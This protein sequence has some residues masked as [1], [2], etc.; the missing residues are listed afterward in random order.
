MVRSGG[1]AGH[2]VDADSTLA[3]AMTDPQPNDFVAEAIPEG[4]PFKR[5]HFGRND[6]GEDAL[7][8]SQP[9]MVTHIDEAAIAALQRHYSKT[10][11]AEGAWLDLMSSWVSHY[12][13]ALPSRVAGLGMNAEELAANPQ[14][15]EWTVHDLNASPVLPYEDESFRAVTIAVS[16]QYLR[17]PVPVFREIGRVLQ[18]DGIC[19]VSFSNRCFPTKAIQLWLSSDDATHIQVVGAYM[20]FATGLRAP[21]ALDLSPAPGASDPLWVVQARQAGPDEGGG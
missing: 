11:S 2:P 12:P 15:S 13:D 4:S 6:E 1:A 17:Q 21:D 20:H 10:L 16:V 18:P 7:F 9:R 19:V 8:Y 14:L 3:G 5:E